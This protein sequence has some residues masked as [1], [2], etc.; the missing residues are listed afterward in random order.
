VLT[1]THQTAAAVFLDGPE[2]AADP[3]DEDYR[4]PQ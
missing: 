1:R 3:T 4:W 2:H